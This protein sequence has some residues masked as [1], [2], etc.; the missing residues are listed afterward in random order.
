MRL[1]IITPHF[2]P[3]NFKVN[4]M[5]FELQRRGHT[6]SVM[7]PIPDYPE[8]KFYKGYG[9]FKKRHEFV[10]GVEVHRSLIIP[11]HSG[12]SI[13]LALNYLSYT[14]FATLKSLWFAWTRKYDAVIVHEPSPVLVG[15]PAVIIKKIQRIPL[16][17]WVLDLWPESLTAAGGIKNKKILAPFEKLTRWIYRNCNTI[18]VGSRGFEQSICDKGDFRHKIEFFPNWVEDILESPGSNTVPTLPDGFNIVSAG[19]MG[20][21]QDLP[22]VMEAVL[23]LKDHKINFNFIGDGRKREF[24]EQFAKDHGL[25]DRVFCYGRYP[26]ECMPSFF[27]QA[28]LLFFALKDSPIFSLTVPSRLQAFMSS[29]KPVVAMINGEGASTIDEADCGWSV[30]ASSP[31]A[32]ADLLLKL[33]SYDKETL[34]RKGANGKTYSRKHYNFSRCIDHLEQIINR[35]KD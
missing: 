28:D 8:G 34:A 15:I 30:P 10:D 4:D 22:S 13:W 35:N 25:T 32:L 18:M 27:S 1:L 21:A 5:A 17:F 12:S 19:N 7:T 16:H 24:V 14:F 26:M 23:R 6:V 33:S 29:G 9:I 11:R 2:H 20:D 3:E 31:E